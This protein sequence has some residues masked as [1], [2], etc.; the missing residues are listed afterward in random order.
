VELKLAKPNRTK[1]VRLG[2]E[3]LLDNPPR[4]FRNL[5]AGLLLNQAS[6]DSSLVPTKDR[7]ARRF[8][9][10]VTA[11]FTPQHGFYGTEQA[12]MIES[13]NGVDPGLDVPVYSLYGKTRRPTKKML[14]SCDVLIVDLQDVGTRVYTFT[15]TMA[16][17]MEACK[18]RGKKVLVLDRP[19]PIGGNQVE[20]NV[21]ARK[22]RSFVGPFPI[23]MRHG[24]TMGELA[25]LIN[26]HFGIGCDLEVIAMQRWKRSMTFPQTGL[27]WIPPSPNIP[28]FDSALV[29]PGQVLLEGTNIS[30]G[31]GTTTPFELFGA[32]FIDAAAL[33]EKLKQR[34]FR[35]VTLRPTVFRPTFGKWQ[36]T[37]CK[38]FQIHVSNTKEYRPY[39]TALAILQ[40]IFT[41]H[42]NEAAWFQ[43]P[44]EYELTKRPIDILT[45]DAKI[46]KAIE[47]GGDLKTLQSSW[48]SELKA[49]LKVTRKFC[50]Y[51]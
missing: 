37:P 35:G 30:E 39:A 34:R 26:D 41:L 19:N 31:R 36:G 9:K 8:P 42:P 23:P 21:L 3:V 24:L 49:F 25:L 29:Y 47:E 44:Y 5:R 1:R 22:F 7:L 17:C 18:Q 11:L 28:T 33:R 32:P 40:D 27:P 20:G 43:P 15:A 12:N 13:P 50:L 16:N 4:W 51:P 10:V 6:V 14:D 45:G 46:R 2:I 48:Q 38:G